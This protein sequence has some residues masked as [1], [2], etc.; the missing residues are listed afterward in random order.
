MRLYTNGSVDIS[1]DDFP[2]IQSS[3]PDVDHA[4]WRHCAGH[5]DG[6]Y[7][8]YWIGLL[9]KVNTRNHWFSRE[10]SYHLSLKPT[11]WIHCQAIFDTCCRLFNITQRWL[12][13]P[14]PGEICRYLLLRERIIKRRSLHPHVSPRF[15]CCEI[16]WVYQQKGIPIHTTLNLHHGIIFVTWLIHRREFH[17][18]WDQ[19]LKIGY[20]MVHGWFIG[21]QYKK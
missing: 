19:M 9:G 3:S 1:M 15:Y 7:I 14:W 17:P 8:S 11:N 12:A 6:M 10:C 21:G 16:K 20:P 4:L 18:C 5:V 2:G 13:K